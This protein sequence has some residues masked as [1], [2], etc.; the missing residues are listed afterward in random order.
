MDVLALITQKGGAGKSTLAQHIAGAACA[1]G[2][3]T[4]LIDA[5]PQQSAADWYQTREQNDAPQVIAITPLELAKA[6]EL[7]RKTFDLVVIDTP[8][9]DAT[10][11]IAEVVK[12]A[13]FCLV[14]SRPTMKDMKGAKPTVRAIKHEDTPAAFVITH[15][16][17]KGGRADTARRALAG[18]HGLP[19]VPEIIP[20]RVGYEDADALGM[21]IAE[22]MEHEPSDSNAKGAA[23]ITTLWQWTK[24]RLRRPAVVTEAAE[25]GE[26]VYA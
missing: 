9:R 16:R 2:T 25:K 12:L 17:K 22:L 19:V 20:H 10:Q 7:A 14:P 24:Q 18:M 26:E 4:L 15:C 3:K 13:D 1:D 5:D 21:T 23:E 6:V 8:G 11:V